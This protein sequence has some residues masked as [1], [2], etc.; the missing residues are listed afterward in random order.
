MPKKTKFTFLERGTSAIAKKRLK[1]GVSLTLPAYAFQ[2]SADCSE[3]QGF[4]ISL[5]VFLLYLV[6]GRQKI[7]KSV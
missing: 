6:R 4:T 5:S 1:K 3:V 2:L 7:K